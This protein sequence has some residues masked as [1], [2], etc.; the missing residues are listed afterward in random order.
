M[1]DTSLIAVIAEK[2]VMNFDAFLQSNKVI[3]FWFNFCRFYRK[4]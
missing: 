4:E 3:K 2:L 1:I